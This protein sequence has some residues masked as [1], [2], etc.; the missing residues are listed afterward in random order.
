[1]HVEDGIPRKKSI[2]P[3]IAGKFSRIIIKPL[4]RVEV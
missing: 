4:R 1:M 3:R 2:F